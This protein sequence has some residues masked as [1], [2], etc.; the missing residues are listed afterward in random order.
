MLIQKRKYRRRS[1]VPVKQLS[2]QRLWQIRQ[3]EAGLCILCS[4]PAWRAGSCHCEKHRAEHAAR[5]KA[6]F[7]RK[8]NPPPP[9]SLW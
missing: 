7:H 5:E 9:P 6:R 8:N 1:D 3:R 4:E 2:R